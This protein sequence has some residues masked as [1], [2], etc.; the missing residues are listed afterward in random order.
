MH[1]SRT[2]PRPPAT[3]SGLEAMAP[4]PIPPRIM[5]VPV[6]S[7]ARAFH[8]HDS[9]AES[10]RARNA[11]LLTTSPSSAHRASLSSPRPRPRSAASS[12][13]SVYMDATDHSIASDYGDRMMSSSHDIFAVE[14]PDL[15]DSGAEDTPNMTLTDFLQYV[16]IL[17]PDQDIPTF[18]A[19]VAGALANAP[20]HSEDQALASAVTLPELKMYQQLVSE[21]KQ[22]ID[23]HQRH[24]QRVDDDIH[25][26]NPAFFSEY[27]EGEAVARQE[28]EARFFSIRELTQ[29]Q[30]H[31]AWIK[32]QITRLDAFHNYITQK[33]D[34]LAKDR[35]LIKHVLAYIKDHMPDLLTYQH[36]LK[37]TTK[38]L[39]VRERDY[40]AEDRTL[41]ARWEKDIKDQEM[42]LTTSR[43]EVKKQEK[44]A[45]EM[46]ARLQKLQIR[47][48]ELKQAI[49]QAQATIDAHPYVSER[50]LADAKFNY[51]LCTTLCGLQL[52]DKTEHTI[53]MTVLNAL[54]VEIDFA[55]LRSHQNDAVLIRM[56]D[57]KA[58][59]AGHFAEL[60][61]GL[62]LM[63]RDLWKPDDIV[64]KIAIYWN[65]VLLIQREIQNVQ[66]R[67]WMK[68]KPLRPES[69]ATTAA[70]PSPPP[71]PPS[72]GVHCEITVFSY[73]HN[74]KFFIT[75][76]ICAKQ[77]MAFPY[78]LDTD[79]LHVRYFNGPS[80][81]A[82]IQQ[83]IMDQIKLKGITDF[84]GSIQS[85]INEIP[86]PASSSSS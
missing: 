57:D 61:H 40:S 47:K 54:D 34:E 62:Q 48:K 26:N 85:V 24:L 27:M 28:V 65:R 13:G 83:V 75:F 12:P 52:I 66:R 49:E 20:V 39:Q 9:L 16:G 70:A 71:S 82:Y 43:R 17:F 50:D 11:A 59:E 72:R 76:N 46:N 81:Q 35:F 38:E 2:S 7:P 51:D 36:E 5:P 29:M 63:A 18:H 69:Q 23:A 67:F 79:T 32:A 84:I 10:D 33:S 80:S 68:I 30:A 14:Q 45:G 6:Y 44:V 19:P 1:T 42:V 56:L 41:V 3:L 8:L 78:S 25:E 21:M 74:L 77:V 55:K 64:R 4:S 22:S 15:Y 60:V 37:R 86:I 53:K 73:P 58:R 31:K